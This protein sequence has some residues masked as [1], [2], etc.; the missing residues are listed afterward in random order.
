MK[1]YLLYVLVPVLVQGLILFGIAYYVFKTDVPEVTSHTCS[2]STHMSCD[3]SC[4]C[5]GVGCPR[6][7]Y[8]VS[9]EE[10]YMVI[11]DYG[12]IVAEVPWNK[13]GVL[14]SIFIADN[15]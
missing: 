4:E 2:D 1:K 12:R 15:E 11:S 7:E 9:L 13:T 3:G 14:D 6:A 5:D 10:D 8:Q